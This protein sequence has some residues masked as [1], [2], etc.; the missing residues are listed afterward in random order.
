MVSSGDHPLFCSSADIEN[1][2]IAEDA[3]A[4]RNGRRAVRL[5]SACQAVSTVMY[6]HL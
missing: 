5:Q 2:R 6:L 1:E 3:Q 4:G